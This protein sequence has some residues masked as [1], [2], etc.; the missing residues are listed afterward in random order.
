MFTYR[1][2]WLNSIASP[3]DHLRRMASTLRGVAVGTL[4]ATE[5][6]LRA[7]LDPSSATYTPEK[8]GRW[9]DADW[10]FAG[11]SVILSSF[12]ET[13]IREVLKDAGANVKESHRWC[14]VRKSF[15]KVSTCT[16]EDVAHYCEVTRVRELA[17]S[18]KHNNF[19]AR[20]QLAE[21]SDHQKGERLSFLLEPWEDLVDATEGFLKDVFGKL[22]PLESPMPITLKR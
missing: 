1:A 15:E 5:E 16:F 20:S 6:D 8:G 18:F 7:Q 17:N 21:V 9:A 2:Y 3:L 12:T 11:Y 4:A 14:R 22:P 19:Q 13:V 10:F